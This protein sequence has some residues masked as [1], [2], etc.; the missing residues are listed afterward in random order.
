MNTMDNSILERLSR[1]GKANVKIVW[2]EESTTVNLGDMVQNDQDAVV[3][4][5][6]IW[7]GTAEVSRL[8]H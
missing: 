4:G 1:Y 8:L 3:V 6:I 5:R 7:E 2:I